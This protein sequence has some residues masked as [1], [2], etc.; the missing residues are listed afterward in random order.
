MIYY[1][2]MKGVLLFLIKPENTAIRNG[3]ARSASWIYENVLDTTS[4]VFDVGF[5]WGRNTEYLRSKGFE[6]LFGIETPAQISRKT[7]ILHLFEG[8]SSEFPSF[9]AQVILNS[10]VLNVI[11]E[12]AER[13]TLL[14]NMYES[15]APQ[16]LLVIEV[17]GTQ[18]ISKAKTKAPYLDGFLMGVQ[19]VKTF[20]KGYTMNEL[21]S[22][23]QGYGTL[24]ETFKTSDSVGVV[25][26]KDDPA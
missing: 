24:L 5:G 7:D 8:V 18:G 25:I 11:P 9:S 26:R 6:H 3:H 17:R 21:I 16:G 2:Y 23:V 14:H 15:L 1:L 22:F 10:F 4:I 19:S 12:Q 20:Q 13:L